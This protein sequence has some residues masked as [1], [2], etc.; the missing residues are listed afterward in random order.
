MTVRPE[1]AFPDT[2]SSA[3]S[4]VVDEKAIRALPL[5]RRSPFSLVLLSPAV[6]PNRS[7]ALLGA[8]SNDFQVSGNRGMSNEVYVDGSPSTVTEGGI[9]SLRA[10]AEGRTL[11]GVRE[12]R[13]QTGIAAAEFGGAGGIVNISTKGGSSRPHGALF[14]F[15]RNSALD[16]NSF[17]G[18]ARGARLESFRRHQAGAALGGPLR[19]P[20]AATGTFGFLSLETVNATASAPY[21]GSVPAIAMRRATSRRRSGRRRDC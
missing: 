16:A 10:V 3:M 19:L 14:E 8:Y 7:L 5:N 13:V 2:A 15:L 17:F 11:E 12:F 6:I 18:N 20:G 4:T 1:T 9:G 21:F